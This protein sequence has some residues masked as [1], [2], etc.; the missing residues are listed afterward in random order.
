MKNIIG[1]DYIKFLNEIKSHIISARIKTARSVNGELIK[2]YWD[3]GR[4]IITRQE[5]HGWG[6]SVVE[7]LAID[8]TSEF[9]GAEGFSVQNLWRMRLLYLAYKDNSKLA[10]LVREIPWGQNIVIA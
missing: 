4:I 9:N 6:Q 10:Q 8:L 7:K 3:I 1:K 2:L 5:K